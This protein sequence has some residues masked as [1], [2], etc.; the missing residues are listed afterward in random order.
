[1]AKKPARGRPPKRPT[2]R[3]TAELRI[4]L[5]EA[6][7]KRIDAQA[8]VAQME[9]STW[10]RGILMAVCKSRKLPELQEVL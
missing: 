10:A 8:K 7:R 9:S 5:T 6:E 1:M 3:K 4:R 2:E